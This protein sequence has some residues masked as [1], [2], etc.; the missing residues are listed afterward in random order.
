MIRPEELEHWFTYHPPKEGE[1]DK[2][3]ELRGKALELASM[4]VK[5]CPES[6]D[7]TFAIRQL[8]GVVMWANASIAC[9]GR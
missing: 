8:R 5:L 9:Q 3:A 6:A 7:L 4:M 1:I 2:Y